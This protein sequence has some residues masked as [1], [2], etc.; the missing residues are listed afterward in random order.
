[1]EK[2]IIKNGILIL[3]IAILFSN[4]GR[5]TTGC[6]SF[7]DIGRQFTLILNE[8][9]TFVYNYGHWELG[10]VEYSFGHY[11][12]DNEKLI[13]NSVFTKVIDSLLIVP[14]KLNYKGFIEFILHPLRGD[15]YGSIYL[16]I[17]DSTVFYPAFDTIIL[18]DSTIDKS[19]LKKYILNINAFEIHKALLPETIKLVTT[20][21]EIY[22]IP[23]DTTADKYDIFYY[24]F[25]DDSLNNYRF[26]ENEKWK[27]HKRRIYEPKRKLIFMKTK[28]C[29]DYF[30]P[31][32]EKRFHLDRH[33]TSKK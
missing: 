26:L 4:C 13:L 15:R 29:P 1:M 16:E 12:I 5:K 19:I 23:I 31:V 27:I 20:N 10:V 30:Q 2:P 21:R 25:Y 24:S 32:Y 11:L 17:D 18:F 6:Y 7:K 22:T 3:L 8:D 33:K 28:K 9:S 14:S